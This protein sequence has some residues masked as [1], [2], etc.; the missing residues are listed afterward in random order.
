MLNIRLSRVGKKGHAQYKVVVAEKSSPVKG[1]FV[2]QV[3]SYDPHTKELKV[4]KDRIEHWISKGAACSDTVK[5][6]FIDREI[7][8]GEKIKLVFKKKNK[9]GEATD[10]EQADKNEDKES[11]TET[12]EEVKDEKE[13]EKDS[14]SE[15]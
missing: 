6:L 13:K 8:Q 3:G 10:E 12:K 5:N 2:E 4:K 15:E 14:G 11:E 1:K 9:E 7:I